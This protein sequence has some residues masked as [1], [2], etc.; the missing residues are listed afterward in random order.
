MEPVM[1]RIWVT[2]RCL[3]GRMTGLHVSLMKYLVSVNQAVPV[4]THLIK[5]I[6]HLNN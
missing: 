6:I 3:Q 2:I 5:E 4:H 1:G